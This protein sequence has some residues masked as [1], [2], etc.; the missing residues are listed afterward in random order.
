MDLDG[1]RYNEYMLP[2][3]IRTFPSKKIVLVAIFICI[4]AFLFVT[5]YVW[6][7]KPEHRLIRGILATSIQDEFLYTGDITISYESENS[8]LLKFPLSLSGSFDG[9]YKRTASGLSVTG[10][11]SVNAR[12]REVLKAQVTKIDSVLFVNI[13]NLSELGLVD[14]NSIT[15]RWI[16]FDLAVIPDSYKQVHLLFGAPVTN[17]NSLL[18]FNMIRTS[19][20]FKVEDVST[21]EV[22]ST[23]THFRVSID[24]VN[25]ARMVRNLTGND[26]VRIA[27]YL[28]K[29]RFESVDI[30]IDEKTGLVQKI[31]I[32]GSR[33]PEND[34]TPS[35]QIKTTIH[36]F[37]PTSPITIDTPQSSESVDTV[38]R[39]LGIL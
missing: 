29:I 30:T 5:F 27:E 2:N 36:F 26:S 7:N 19:Q 28:E 16:S 20:S 11:V 12:D 3:Q 8:I 14:N 38:I 24:N 15:N 21:D 17:Q 34:S 25:A 37:M 35:I 13:L 18:L 39:D 9:K 33:L 32:L 31:T 1:K 23:F 22:N 4:L 6:Y 10:L